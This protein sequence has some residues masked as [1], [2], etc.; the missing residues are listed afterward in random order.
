MSQSKL[1]SSKMITYFVLGV[2]LLALPLALQWN[3]Y[4]FEVVQLIMIYIILALGVRLTLLMGFPTL[5]HGSFALIGAYV[6]AL[7]VTRL[8]LSFWFALPLAGAAAVLV[9]VPV[10]YPSLM[11]LKGGYFLVVTIAFVSLLQLV[12]LH[13]SSLTGG[14]EG[15]SGIPKP[16]P[17]VLPLLGTVDFSS[18]VAFYYVV[19]VITV[20][21]VFFMH[22]LDKS[23]FGRLIKATRQ[24]DVLSECVGVNVAKIRIITF[25]IACFSGGVAGSLFAHGTQYICPDQFGIWPSL[26]VLLFVVFGGMGSVLGS[27]LGTIILRIVPELLV[28]TPMLSAIVFGILLLFV[29]HFFPEGILGL[30]NQ[31]SSLTRINVFGHRQANAQRDS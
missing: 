11:R 16:D 21:I 9:G 3:L 22:K 28:S 25:A 24:S 12:C 18:R 15:I 20:F 7:L 26:Y 19:L 6:S 17:I 8:G 4:S 10:C 2:I 29:A 23:S 14:E 13:F 5:G 1:F 31:V 30:G 27:V